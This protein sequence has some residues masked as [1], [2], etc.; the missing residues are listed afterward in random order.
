MTAAIILIL[1]CLASVQSSLGKR[2]DCGSCTCFGNRQK[3]TKAFCT[4][5]Q[6]SPMDLFVPNI[7][8]K[9]IVSLVITGKWVLKDLNLPVLISVFLA[10]TNF[11]CTHFSGDIQCA[12]KFSGSTKMPPIV[13]PTFPPHKLPKFVTKKLPIA[14]QDV[15]KDMT[16]TPKALTTEEE[17]TIFPTNIQ[18]TKLPVPEMP[19]VTDN[20]H[21]LQPFASSASNSSVILQI[22]LPICTFILGMAATCFVLRIKKCCAQKPKTKIFKNLPQ[23]IHNISFES[24]DSATLEVID[25]DEFDGQDETDDHVIMHR[26]PNKYHNN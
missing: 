12:A 5:F 18:V 17:A 16:S 21:D 11:K 2:F 19:Y 1:L 23:T 3:I 8:A 9:R 10:N 26:S 22:L 25:L 6:D 13:L 4:N 20:R 7:F 14:T 24:S 15:T